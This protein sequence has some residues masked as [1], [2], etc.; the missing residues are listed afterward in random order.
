MRVVGLY[1]IFVLGGCILFEMSRLYSHMYSHLAAGFER[2]ARHGCAPNIARYVKLARNIGFKGNKSKK[3]RGRGRNKGKR[4]LRAQ[5]RP[6]PRNF[7]EYSRAAHAR[8]Y[9][10]KIFPESPVK[11]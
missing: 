8:Q 10:H 1:G 4:P 5:R 11:P 2:I 7:R 9:S 3:Y 6:G